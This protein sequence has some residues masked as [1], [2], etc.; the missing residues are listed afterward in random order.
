MTVSGSPE[1]ILE[2]QCNHTTWKADRI[3]LSG[4]LV[5]LSTPVRKNG[6][7]DLRLQGSVGKGKENAI[8]CKLK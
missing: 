5:V 8:P 1:R 3:I 4:S 6:L 7:L 2:T